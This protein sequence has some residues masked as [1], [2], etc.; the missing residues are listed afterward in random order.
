[1]P[2]GVPLI[3]GGTQ[4]STLGV[5]DGAGGVARLYAGQQRVALGPHDHQDAAAGL[6]DRLAEESQ[7]Y[8]VGRQLAV[9]E[10]EHAVQI[11]FAGLSL[12]VQSPAEAVVV[13]EL[14]GDEVAGGC[15]QLG[16][17]RAIE[18]IV[19]EVVEIVV[20]QELDH[21]VACAVDLFRTDRDTEDPVVGRRRSGR[22]VTLEL[23][24][25]QLY[26]HQLHGPKAKAIGR[27][28]GLGATMEPWPL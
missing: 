9:G 23:D 5:G 22:T 12:G 24:P 10:D 6:V 27:E 3:D 20:Q 2:S 14:A 28:S 15:S 1:M 13:E 7:P 11:A 19:V 25:L 18:E 8:V 17:Q 26:A 16:H 4:R 21:R